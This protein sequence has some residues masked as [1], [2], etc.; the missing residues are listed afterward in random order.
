MKKNRLHS[1][2]AILVFLLLLLLVVVTISLKNNGIVKVVSNQNKK[3]ITAVNEQNNASIWLKA[4]KVRVEIGDN[5]KISINTNQIEIA[6]CTIYLYFDSS[7]LQIID[8]PENANV[9]ENQII[10]TW[11]DERTEKIEQ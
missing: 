2:I 6:A 10:Y 8:I 4:D 3:N 5:I 11:Y 9:I 7:K 1:N